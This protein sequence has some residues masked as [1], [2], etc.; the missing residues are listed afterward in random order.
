MKKAIVFIL[1]VSVPSQMTNCVTYLQA[2]K[3]SQKHVIYESA[4]AK[5]YLEKA[6]MVPSKQIIYNFKDFKK[7]YEES[8]NNAELVPYYQNQYFRSELYNLAHATRTS[9][10]VVKPMIKPLLNQ[11][12][13]RID[14]LVEKYAEKIDEFEKAHFYF[15]SD[16]AHMKKL[17]RSAEL[18][19]WSKNI[20][21]SEFLEDLDR[22][23]GSST[24]PV[25]RD[26]RTWGPR[27]VPSGTERPVPGRDIETRQPR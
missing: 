9:P 15:G 16:E 27:E 20:R 13:E 12:D 22:D 26:P 19:E 8:L 18:N 4:E 23:K 25:G 5:Y 17:S 10:E 21:K 3:Q 7:A 1:C 6:T 11:I 24:E 14:S 2:L